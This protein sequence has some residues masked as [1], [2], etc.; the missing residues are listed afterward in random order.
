[1]SE[2]FVRKAD[3]FVS[4]HALEQFKRRFGIQLNR[5][6]LVNFI[7][8][9]YMKA[10]KLPDREYGG[11]VMYFEESRYLSHFD[12]N[13]VVMIVKEKTI[14]TIWEVYRDKNSAKWR[15]VK[16]SE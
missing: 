15:F 9:L 1:M 14:I 10:R 5:K 3:V 16:R 6:E 13:H 4:K 2:L 7:L 11:K 8:N 12:N